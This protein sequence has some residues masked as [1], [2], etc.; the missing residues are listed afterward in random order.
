MKKVIDASA[1]R[2][3]ALRAYLEASPTNFAVLPEMAALE[4]FKGD[5]AYNLKRSLEILGAFPRQVIVL[6]PNEEIVKLDPRRK[7][8]HGR[9]IDERQTANFGK[10]CRDVLAGP[11]NNRPVLRDL[12]QKERRA[13]LRFRQL[14]HGTEQLR[15][16]IELMQASYLPEDLKALRAKRPISDAFAERIMKDIL[17][18][19]A[20]SF[21]D[22]IGRPVDAPM[23]EEIIYSLQFRY[24]L[25][26]HILAMK[27]IGDG[28]HETVPTPKLRNDFS[29]MNYAAYATFFDGLIT[30][31]RKLATVYD[32]AVW[33]LANVFR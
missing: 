2:S 1:L 17:M 19:T 18:C 25:C 30:E 24:A 12:W 10:F 6:K 32:V 9:L 29:D 8:L 28:G 31:D 16:G 15:Y 7:G 3:P 22:S 5:A 20:I 26:C 27:W 21:R 4:S 14:L 23:A 33:M 11:E 13:N